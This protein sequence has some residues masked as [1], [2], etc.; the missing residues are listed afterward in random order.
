MTNFQP[1]PRNEKKDY[2]WSLRKDSW[3]VFDNDCDF[4]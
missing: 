3:D 4:L 1:F 2:H